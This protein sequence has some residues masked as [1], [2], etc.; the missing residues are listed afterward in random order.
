MKKTGLK[1]LLK[2]KKT[3]MNDMLKNYL[4]LTAGFAALSPLAHAQIIYTDVNPDLVLTGTNS[5]DIDLNNDGTHEYRF[6]HQSYSNNNY[7]NFIVGDRGNMIFLAGFEGSGS[8]WNYLPV[9]LNFNEEMITSGWDRVWGAGWRTLSK[10]KNDPVGLWKGLK[11]KYAGLH[12]RIDSQFYY[13]WVRLD[14]AADGKSITIKDYAYNS[15]VGKSIKAGVTKLSLPDHDS[16]KQIIVYPING[17]IRIEAPA[18]MILN[19]SIRLTDINGRELRSIDIKNE[20]Y[21]ELNTQELPGGVYIVN[22]V[23]EWG[24]LTKKVLIR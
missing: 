8:L 12:F 3:K 21:I 6:N 11:D 19:G 14:V 9:P 7:A 18:D 2:R 17:K 16:L 23:T 1:L 10:S 20:K 15:Q 22:I 5:I 24:I 4:A 13:G